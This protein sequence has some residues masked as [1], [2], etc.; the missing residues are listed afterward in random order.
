MQLKKLSRLCPESPGGLYFFALYTCS[1]SFL[2]ESKLFTFFLREGCF[3]FDAFIIPSNIL[4]QI[5]S[6]ICG[7]FKVIWWG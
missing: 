7:K 3:W 2:K 4:L 6:E 5:H 1:S